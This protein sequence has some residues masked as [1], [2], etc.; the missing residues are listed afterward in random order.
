M[1]HLLITLK[2][3]LT[4]LLSQ[5][6]T[7][8]RPMLNSQ[9]PTTNSAEEETAI[10]DGNSSSISSSHTQKSGLS[11]SELTSDWEEQSKSMTHGS[12]LR[13]LTYGGAEVTGIIQPSSRLTKNSMLASTRLSCTVVKTV[14]M[15]QWTS[16]SREERTISNLYPRLTWR[17]SSPPPKL[18]QWELTT[19][20]P[21]MLSQD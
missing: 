12:G 21:S 4:V 9:L 8:P 20:F 5:R 19:I 7:V 18:Q 17:L 3:W 16:D 11:S 14:A 6:A 10:L 1:R 13:I 2:S 15:D